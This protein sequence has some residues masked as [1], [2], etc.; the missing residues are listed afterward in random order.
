MNSRRYT[1][2]SLSIVFL[3]VTI[4]SVSALGQN[5][6]AAGGGM[7]LSAECSGSTCAVSGTSDRSDLDVTLKV[8]HPVGSTTNVDVIDQLS[9]SDVSFS[10]TIN[11]SILKDGTYTIAAN[12]GS[13]SKYNLSVSVDVSDG[14]ST[15]SAS[16]S[17]QAAAAEEEAGSV[18]AVAASG[19]TLT[20]SGVEGS[21]TIDV[22]GTTDRTG[23]IT[24]KVTAPNGN[25][26]AADQISPSGGSFMTTI[27]VG[28]ALWNQDGMYTISAH[29]GAASNY[30]TSAE[31]EI[32]DGHVIPEFGVIAAMILAVAIVSIIVVT[33]KTRLSIVPRY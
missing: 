21:T 16:V 18:E 8:T 22:S 14:T 23:D 1:M 28:G 29:Q 3:A 12:Q 33:A 2:T 10:T 30:Q 32:I 5:A 27:E 24:I 13:S 17:N 25:V 19:L 9:V 26:V 20:A 11:V 4:M 31:I 15:S 6:Y 7:S